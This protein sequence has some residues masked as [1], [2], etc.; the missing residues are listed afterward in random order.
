MCLFLRVKCLF[1]H[2][3]FE[4]CL[5]LHAKLHVHFTAAR[6][7]DYSHVPFNLDLYFTANALF[8]NK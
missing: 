7:E 6:P 5:F 2:A 8:S 4:K 1:L 3:V